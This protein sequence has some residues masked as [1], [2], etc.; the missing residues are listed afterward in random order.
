MDNKLNYKYIFIAIGT[1]A[2]WYAA[3]SS[4]IPAADFITYTIF[5]M[6][7]EAKLGKAVHFFLYDTAKILLLMVMLIYVIGFVRASLSVE[8]VRNFLVGKH[9]IVGYSSAAIFGSVTPFCSCSSVPLFIGFTTA[10]IPL[11]MTMTFLITSPI[12]NE[13]AVIILLGMLG[14]KFTVVYVLIGLSMGILGGVIMNKLKAERF[15]QDYLQ[16]D[17]GDVKMMDV[18]TKFSLADRHEFAYTEMRDITKRIWKWVIVG[19]G[20]GAL[21]HGY[22]PEEF[23][24]EHLNADNWLAVPGAVLLGIP[25]YTNAT[26]V[27]P[28]VE[29]LIGN[30]MPV[31]TTMALSMSAVALSLPELIM[32][33]QVMKTELIV[34]FVLVMFVL[35]VLMGWLLNVVS[36]YLVLVA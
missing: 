5:Q 25:L 31:G 17:F 23:I 20:I 34:R 8:R 29:S 33:K 24:I 32:L 14:W 3:Y 19:V 6:E 22:V 10:K 28:I 9:S 21:L 35:F 18:K 16:K 12:I 1:F 27:M 11:G 2:V 4:L 15:L 30:S 13:V 26:G 36:P 7:P